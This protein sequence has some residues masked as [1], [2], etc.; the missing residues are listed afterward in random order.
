MYSNVLGQ[1]AVLWRLLF[2]MNSNEGLFV[3]LTEVFETLYTPVKLL[4]ESGFATVCAG[5]RNAD[6][7][8]VI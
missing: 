6:G 3:C 8:K 4:G 1:K 2:Q 5:V 7:K